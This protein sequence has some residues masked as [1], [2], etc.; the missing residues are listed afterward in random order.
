MTFDGSTFFLT[1]KSWFKSVRLRRA[2]PPSNSTLF[3]FRPTSISRHSRVVKHYRRFLKVTVIKTIR[4]RFVIIANEDVLTAS[5]AAL[6]C[7][8]PAFVPHL[9]GYKARRWFL[10][11]T[12][13]KEAHVRTVFR[14]TFVRKFDKFICQP[15]NLPFLF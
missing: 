12:L 1:S 7:Q 11:D 4:P 3:A 15:F 6:L 14:D 10:I 9:I 8:P 13:I 2:P 5:G